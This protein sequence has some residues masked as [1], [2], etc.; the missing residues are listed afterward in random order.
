[1]ENKDKE[2]HKDLVQ[3]FKDGTVTEGLDCGNNAVCNTLR[4]DKTNEAREAYLATLTPE[5]RERY[6]VIHRA[7]ALLDNAKIPFL[8]CAV[9]EDES[10]N[11]KALQYQRFSY[12][13]LYDEKGEWIESSARHWQRMTWEILHSACMVCMY[14]FDGFK[15]ML[16]DPYGFVLNKW[17][18]RKCVSYPA[19][20]KIE[21]E[22]KKKMDESCA[23]V[24]KGTGLL[25]REVV[26]TIATP[27][28]NEEKSEK[29]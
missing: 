11:A 17:E 24:R 1:M 4:Q 3:S 9:P 16:V 18:R 10:P 2:E 22:A 19:P 14:S 26:M 25:E 29:S 8:L 6:E 7:A 27:Y 13:Q 15:A 5:M 21:I 23:D 28:K 20:D 12:R